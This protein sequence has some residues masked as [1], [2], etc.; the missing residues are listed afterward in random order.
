MKA[1]FG[2][3]SGTGVSFFAFQD[4]ITGTSGFLIVLTLF[5]ALN[6]DEALVEGNHTKPY[7]K[8][9]ED[10]RSMQSRIVSTRNL[11]AD[12]QNRPAEDETTL[13]RMI[14][15]WTSTVAEL[16]SALTPGL[17]KAFD[18]TAMDRELRDTKQKLLTRT[19]KMNAS[20]YQAELLSSGLNKEV[21]DLEKKIKDAESSL[22]RVQSRRNVI[23]LVPELSDNKKEPILVLVQ[24]SMIRFQRANGQPASAG[25]IPDFVNYLRAATAATHYVVFYFKPSGANHFESLTRIARQEGFEIGYDV[26][27][28]GLD[29]EFHNSVPVTKP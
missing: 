15:Q 1:R 18:A 17:N 10:L 20:I 24:A 16:E 22:Q 26:I 13:R 9:E 4:I 27:P 6:L 25:S 2:R 8:R 5:L 19:E 3:Q 23:S 28:E 7:A 12:L 21:P 29:V 11:M 14:G